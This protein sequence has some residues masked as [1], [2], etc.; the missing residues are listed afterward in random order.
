MAVFDALGEEGTGSGY[1]DTPRSNARIVCSA[2]IGKR[3]LY[4][5]LM[6]CRMLV[7]AQNYFSRARP[8]KR[9]PAQFSKNCVAM[10]WTHGLL[11][12]GYARQFS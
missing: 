11:A 4:P 7:D 12:W 10:R 2:P 3:N 1:C 8:G 5:P 9:P 6:R